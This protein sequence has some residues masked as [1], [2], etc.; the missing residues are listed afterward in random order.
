VH[1]GSSLKFKIIT[2]L[3]VIAWY[4]FYWVR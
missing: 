2:G 1:N 4:K 3:T